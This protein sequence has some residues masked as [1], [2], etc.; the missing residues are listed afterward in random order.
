M[1]IL[2]ISNT[3]VFIRLL[4]MTVLVYGLFE[5]AFLGYKQY[6][7]ETEVTELYQKSNTIQSKIETIFQSSIAISDGYLSYVSSDLNLTK[8]ESETFLSHLLH[9]ED[10]FLRNIALIEDTTI[11][12]NYPYEG[13]ENSIG[14][15][16]SLVDGQKDQ[17]LFVKNN[18][19]AL[20][21]GPI[22]LIQGGQA[23]I[24]R[25]P[26]IINES[27]YFGQIAFVIDAGL[28]IDVITEEADA[29]GLNVLIKNSDTDESVMS[30]RKIN[31]SL[32][33]SSNYS[34]DY[35]SWEIIVSNQ[36]NNSLLLQAI[37]IRVI[38]LIIISI[39]FYYSYKSKI[40]DKKLKYYAEHDF[41]T[42]DFNR[43]KFYR[44]YNEHAFD[45]RLIAYADIN[46]FKLINDTLGHLFGDWVL[47][48][49]SK[50]FNA[51]KKFTVYRISGDEFI[52]ASNET[53][54]FN[55]FKNE[56]MSSDLVFYSED[57]K[58]NVELKL[59]FGVFEKLPK[60][61]S[62]EMVLMYLDYAMYDAKNETRTFTVITDELMAH[63]NEVKVVEHQ[64][65]EDVQNNRLIPYY[66]PII[67]VKTGKIDGFE[68]LSRWLYQG[69]ILSADQFMDILK[70]TKYVGLVDRN[71]FKKI[72]KD[73]LELTSKNEQI[74]TM[75]FSINLS[76][77]VLMNIERDHQAFDY[78]VEDRS[79]PIEKI[80]LEISEDMN[81]GFISID[82]LRYMQKKGYNVTVDDFGAGVSKLSDVLSGELRRI[83]TDKSLL[84]A[85]IKKTKTMQGFYT[86]IKAIKASGSTICV[87]G[88]ETIEQLNIA[89]D[90]GCTLVQGFFF[91]K[92][93]PKE[94][95]IP[96]IEN[97]DYSKYIKQ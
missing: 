67:N 17:V 20:F 77:E 64:I 93:M 11:K 82:T 78:F 81:L 1:L 56:V 86:V 5:L 96:F 61:I 29:S 32:Y 26:I 38:I 31:D 51:L 18:K 9:Y 74:N 59:S 24:L 36:A 65:I 37:I 14:V 41:L 66:Q 85:N 88:V 2:K 58:Q 43:I 55:E 46:K 33:I 50:R 94:D 42:N 28:L 45:N 3:R 44:D 39:L 7:N 47:S 13:N 52:L 95:V 10:N 27:D 73:Y 53:M 21:L 22:E 71:L 75:T 90:A 48:Q 15:D 62:L 70:K 57:I 49:V 8:E 97:F 6:L 34:N 91:A 83:K 12:Y 54:T 92:P 87:E 79:I 40:L 23:F 16:L 69:E 19:E 4:M 72:Q 63:Y 30:I 89:I 76:A 80:I 25:I 35:F 60:T 84:P 68:A